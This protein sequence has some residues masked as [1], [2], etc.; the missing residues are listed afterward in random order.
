MK[1][2]NTDAKL[3]VIFELNQQFLGRTKLNLLGS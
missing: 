2:K 3:E 1:I